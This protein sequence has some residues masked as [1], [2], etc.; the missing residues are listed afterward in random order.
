MILIYTDLPVT[1]RI[2]SARREMYSLLLRDGVGDLQGG[3]VTFLLDI[4]KI[5]FCC[6]LLFRNYF[7]PSLLRSV[8]IDEE[9]Q[10]K[11]N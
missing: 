7:L 11:N 10:R 9:Q 6:E 5:N 8:W 1:C 3:N 2:I 4:K